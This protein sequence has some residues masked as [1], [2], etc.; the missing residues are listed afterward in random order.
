LQE[1]TRIRVKEALWAGS[2]KKMV[3]IVVGIS[4]TNNEIWLSFFLILIGLFSYWALEQTKIRD[5]LVFWSAKKQP[6]FHKKKEFCYDVY[7]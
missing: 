2:P 4:H 3:F 7:N 6:S 5:I 1:H